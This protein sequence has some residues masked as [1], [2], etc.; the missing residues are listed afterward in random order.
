[1]TEEVL[2]PYVSTHTGQQIESS[3]TKILELVNTSAEIN[4][5]VGKALKLDDIEY[6]STE[7]VDGTAYYI[8]WKV[9]PTATNTVK[10]FAMHPTTGEL[11]IINSVNNVKTASFLLTSS[12][13]ITTD[14]VED[15][16][17]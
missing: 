10:G 16:F 9:K 6:T 8:I 3:I 17:N 1:M 14:E 2:N 12:D 7:G 4:S 11:V 15:L 13:N 5:A